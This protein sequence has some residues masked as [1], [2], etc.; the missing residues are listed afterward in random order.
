M[1][2]PRGHWNC[3]ARPRI[4][5]LDWDAAG[6]SVRF[7]A[8]LKPERAITGHGRPLHGPD[9]QRA[10]DALAQDFER[11]AAPERGRYVERPARAADG[12]A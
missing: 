10:L 5:T 3:T 4:L 12:S 2:S 6:A 7:L 9:L 1:P 8:S 11:V